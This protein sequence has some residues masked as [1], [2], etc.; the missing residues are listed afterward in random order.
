[1]VYTENN[2]QQGNS[3]TAETFVVSIPL[4]DNEELDEELDAFHDANIDQFSKC[5]E[6]MVGETYNIHIEG[7]NHQ[8]LQLQP[9]Q[10]VETFQCPFP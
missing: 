6:T 8:N 2:M 5:S 10:V 4:L 1:M 7:K 3:N 9:K